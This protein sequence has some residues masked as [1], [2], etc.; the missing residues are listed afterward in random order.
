M[1]FEVQCQGHASGEGLPVNS[2][3][4]HMSVYI[5]V[6]SLHAAHKYIHLPPLFACILCGYTHIISNFIGAF[7]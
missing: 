1:I 2:F 3:F 6:F 7:V 5:N 4:V